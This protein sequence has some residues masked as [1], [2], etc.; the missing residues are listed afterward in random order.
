ML[1]FSGVQVMYI[2]LSF[3]LCSES[4]IIKRSF[5]IHRLCDTFQPF[6][7]C[8]KEYLPVCATNRRTYGNICL[9]CIAY[10]RHRGAIMVTRFEAC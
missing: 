10:K 4:S 2:T 8:S 5:Y 1:V 3:L 9:F 6:G 7:Y